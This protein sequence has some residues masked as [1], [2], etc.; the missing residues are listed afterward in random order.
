MDPVDSTYRCQAYCLREKKPYPQVVA[1]NRHISCGA[2]DLRQV[3][4][5]NNALSG[6]S[7][8]IANDAYILYLTEPPGYSL[9]QFLCPGAGAMTSKKEGDLRIVRMNCGK[10]GRIRWSAEYAGGDVR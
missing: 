3:S 5:S 6:E 4:W 7:D 1:T 10:G 8:L 9:Q 2:I